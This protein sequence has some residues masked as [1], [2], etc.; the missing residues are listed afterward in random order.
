MK[1]QVLLP[2]F[3]LCATALWSHPMGNFS[4][5]HYSRIALTGTGAKIRYVLDLAEIPTLQLLQ[6]WKLE[7]GSPR[8]E[9]DRRASEQARI[10]GRM[11]TY[12][13]D[14]RKAPVRFEHASLAIDKGAGGM[15]VMRIVSEF[16][17][18]TPPGTLRYE[19]ANFPDRA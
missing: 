11:L 14:G 12:E 5:S 6:E 7:A 1:R 16:R 15:A 10:W 17:V 8:E 13:V 2:A 3:A 18:D 19:D 4:V 9:L